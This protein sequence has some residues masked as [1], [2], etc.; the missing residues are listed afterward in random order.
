MQTSLIV[1]G[2]DWKL[3]FNA[4]EPTTKQFSLISILN[5]DK[6]KK[7]TFVMEMEN[8]STCHSLCMMNAA[9]SS[10]NNQDILEYRYIA[11]T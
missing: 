2:A 3:H 5:L 11:N 1:I 8:V 7:C 10:T 4:Q 9:E 6:G